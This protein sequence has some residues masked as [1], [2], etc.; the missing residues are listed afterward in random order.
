VVANSFRSRNASH[1]ASILVILFVAMVG[2][3]FLSGEDDS[4]KLVEHE[5]DPLQPRENGL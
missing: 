2:G 4:S 1:F 3:C 5:I